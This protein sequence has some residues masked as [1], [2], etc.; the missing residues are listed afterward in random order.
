MIIKVLWVKRVLK[1]FFFF[2]GNREEKTIKH[3]YLWEEKLEEIPLPSSSFLSACR[4]FLMGIMTLKFLGPFMLLYI[5]QNQISIL[6][7]EGKAN[8]FSSLCMFTFSPAGPLCLYLVKIIHAKR[9]KILFH[10][11]TCRNNTKCGKL[12]RSA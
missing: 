10:A 1:C 7:I 12:T 9:T 8:I 6:K 3:V 5:C 2:F 4:C 11:I